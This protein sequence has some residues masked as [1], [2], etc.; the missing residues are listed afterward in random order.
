MRIF[1]FFS[2][3]AIVLNHA[4]AAPA[5]GNVKYLQERKA[6]AAC[7]KPLAVS[8]AYDVLSVLH[9]S[10]FCTHWLGISTQT[11]SS[12]QK[13]LCNHIYDLLTPTATQSTIITTSTTVLTTSTPI[14]S[15][16]DSSSCTYGF[17]HANCLCNS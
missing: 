11:V 14:V 10:S 8:L 9:A 13:H 7:V 15:D 4:I 17:V 5:P 12:K 16:Y 2:L 1:S 6:P 3:I